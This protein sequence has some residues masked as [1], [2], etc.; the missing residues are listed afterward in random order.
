MGANSIA[1]VTNSPPYTYTFGAAFSGTP[2]VA[3]ATL[4]GVN[5][6]N[7]GWAHVFGAS[8]LSATQLDLVIDEDTIG[9]AER[10]HINEQVGYLVFE[11]AFV[12]P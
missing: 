1:G 6:G 4:A 11:S 10:N 8:P 5:G 9:D 3:I 7:G 2:Q 12:Y